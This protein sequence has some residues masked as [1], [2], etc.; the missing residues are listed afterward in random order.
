MDYVVLFLFAKSGFKR[1]G[2][3]H[4]L[5]DLMSFFP[6]VLTFQ[7]SQLKSSSGVG[8][9]AMLFSAKFDFKIELFFSHKEPKKRV[10]VFSV[11][12]FLN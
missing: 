6:S 11:L 9:W 12:T 5:T 7:F 3:A 1:N 2:S 10:N 8:L 4:V